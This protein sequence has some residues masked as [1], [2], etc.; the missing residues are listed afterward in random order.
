M[1]IQD[2]EYHQAAEMSF[3]DEF[4]ADYGVTA[5]VES[6]LGNGRVDINSRDRHGKT[7]LWYATSDLARKIL[8]DH[9]ATL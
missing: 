7:P 3:Y 9:G 4:L 2:L 5:I 1:L 6:V 8:R